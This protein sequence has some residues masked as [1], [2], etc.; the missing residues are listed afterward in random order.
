MYGSSG[1]WVQLFDSD[2]EYS[3]TILLQESL[4][5]G[6]YQTLDFWKSQDGYDRFYARNKSEISRLDQIGDEF[7]TSEMQIGRFEIVE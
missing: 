1:E 7:T 2:S 4:G 5:K 3:R 6:T